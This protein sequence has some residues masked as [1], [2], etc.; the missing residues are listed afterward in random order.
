MNTIDTV[1][2]I[3]YV[4]ECELEIYIEYI[5]YITYITYITYIPYTTYN[6]K[7]ECEFDFELEH[8]IEYNKYNGNRGIC[9]PY[10]NKDIFTI[11]YM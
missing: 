8:L 7:V 5:P 4:F 1:T 10:K 11:N 3:E 6:S 2:K 9:T